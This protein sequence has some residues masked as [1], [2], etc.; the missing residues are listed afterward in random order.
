MPDNIRITTPVP[1]N[2]GINRVSPSKHTDALQ[3]IDPS[4]VSLPNTEKQGQ[5][6]NFEFLLNRNSVFSKFIDQLGQTPG[7]SQNME[8]I[9][10]DLFSRVQNA[11]YANIPVFLSQLAE[12]MKMEPADILKNLQFLNSSQTKFSGQAFD[13]FRE[14]AARNPG[15][16]FSQKLGEFLKAYDG[17]FSIGDTTSTIIKQLNFMKQQIP[18][19]HSSQLQALT[20]ELTAEQPVE[21]LNRNLAILKDKIIPFLSKYVTAS[22]DFGRV[23][24]NIT[25]MVH[26]LARLNVSSR[27]ELAEK[28]NSLIDFCR[29]D[30]NIPAAKTENIRSMF[31]EHLNHASE[32]P[33]NIFFD[34]L[35]KALSE[36]SQ[37]STSN[38]SQS[39]FKDAVSTLLLDNSVYMPYTHLFLPIS[40]Q[41]QF[42]FTEL[43]IE[44]DDASQSGRKSLPSEKTTRMFITFDIKSLGYFEASIELFQ[45]RANIQINCPPE[46]AGN[47][48]DIRDHITEIFTRNGLTAEHIKLIPDNRPAVAQQIL[49]KVYERKN[50]IDVTI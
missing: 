35:L 17:F 34:S 5:S 22:N 26:N 49:K 32:Q 14:L 39:L 40:Y 10:L 12:T 19:P 11:Q 3:P 21:N 31:I 15:S 27:E 41:G 47:I 18:A 46:L 36:G 25:L 29:Y 7:L 38:M 4:K 6:E 33:E 50:V 9:M 13:V 37:Q 45:K 8:K 48:Q 16:A 1:G 42:M 44:K 23:R 2:D 20:N 43:W 28:F 24:S 30:L